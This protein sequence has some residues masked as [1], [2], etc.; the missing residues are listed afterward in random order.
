MT[1]VIVLDSTPVGLL[2]H[3]RAE[4]RTPVEAWMGELAGTSVVA[5]PEIVLYEVRRELVRLG[6]GG[7]V[8]LLDGLPGQMV[9]ARVTTSILVHASELWAEGRRTGRPTAGPGELDID[10]ILAATALS[11]ASTPEDEVIVATSNVG[12]LSRFVD[13]RP[14]ESIAP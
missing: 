6:S 14:W 1:R 13:A 4:L 12:H 9:Y 11:L 5:L 8:R 7:S 10:V 3:G 2:V